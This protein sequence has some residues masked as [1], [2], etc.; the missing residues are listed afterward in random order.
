MKFEW[1][2]KKNQENIKKHGI[3][4]EEAKTIFF[5]DFLEKPDLDH[6]EEEDRFIAIGISYYTRELMVSYCYRTKVNGEEVIRI[7]SSRKA[8]DNERRDYYERRV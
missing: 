4:F 1:D 6:S 7:I 5:N 2:D 3:P 8:T